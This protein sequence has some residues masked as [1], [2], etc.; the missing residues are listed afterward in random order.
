MVRQAH[1]RW[2]DMM[3]AKT[4]KQ[5]TINETKSVSETE[6]ETLKAGLRVDETTLQH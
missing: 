1:V 4:P 6:Y 3:A 2:R 5:P